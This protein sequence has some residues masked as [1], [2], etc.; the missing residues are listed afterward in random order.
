[1]TTVCFFVFLGQ[2]EQ[3]SVVYQL[4]QDG[5][6]Q[7]AEALC[8]EDDFYVFSLDGHLGFDTSDS[9]DYVVRLKT[10]GDGYVIEVDT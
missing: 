2:K 1:M 8:C 9:R 7:P 6:W 4:W 3:F 10:D 5:S